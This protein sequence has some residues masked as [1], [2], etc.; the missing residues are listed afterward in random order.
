M[1]KLLCFMM[2]AFMAF[3]IT[4]MIAVAETV[5][6]AVV[7][8]P[9]GLDLGIYFATLSGLVTAVI[10]LTQFF[11]TAIET[12]GIKTNYLSWIIALVLSIAGYFLQLGMFYG[13]PWYWIPIYALSA[14]LIA[15]GIAGKQVVEAILS[16]FN[17]KNL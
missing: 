12:H 6:S 4:P 5:A 14:G 15:N 11:K 8:S 10:L 16:L 9:T 3:V 1:K 2:V 17:S 7:D 13:M